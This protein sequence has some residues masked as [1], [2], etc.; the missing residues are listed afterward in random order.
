[1]HCC[2]KTFCQRVFCM[3]FVNV[4]ITCECLYSSLVVLSSNLSGFVYKFSPVDQFLCPLFKKQ[5]RC[6]LPVKLCT[7]MIDIFRFCEFICKFSFSNFFSW[8]F[9]TIGVWMFLSKWWTQSRL[10]YIP[11]EFQG[12]SGRPDFTAFCFQWISLALLSSWTKPELSFLNQPKQFSRCKRTT[13]WVESIYPYS[14]LDQTFF[15]S[16]ARICSFPCKPLCFTQ[17]ATWTYFHIHR[18]SGGSAV[19][20]S[21]V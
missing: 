9:S 11:E 4:L 12:W 20:W 16:R 2:R 21:A 10:T 17:C 18:G 15:R 3:Y 8:K 5:R 6:F 13:T 14:K 1:M 7:V 19:Y